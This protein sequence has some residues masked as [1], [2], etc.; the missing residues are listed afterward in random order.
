MYPNETLTEFVH[1]ALTMADP[2][3]NKLG[4]E[5]WSA[6][7]TQFRKAIELADADLKLN[8]STLAKIVKQ[9][10]LDHDDTSWIV[11]EYIDRVQ[12]KL[13]VPRELELLI[14]MGLDDLVNN[15][16]Q[17]AIFNLKRKPGKDRKF[18]DKLQACCYFK[19]L[20]NE[21]ATYEDASFQCA[22]RWNIDPRT[23][24]RWASEIPLPDVSSVTLETLS[25]ISL[26]P[27]F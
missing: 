1:H 12:Q 8:E 13:P 26:S 5:G 11:N 23:V 16:G 22:E 18:S 21:G 6:F 20:Q 4:D 27:L 25:R 14:A 3:I 17:D 19:Y 10:K 9:S 7:C 2:Y 15:K 24:S